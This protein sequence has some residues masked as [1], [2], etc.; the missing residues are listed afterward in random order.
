MGHDLATSPEWS[1]RTR[2]LVLFFV[3]AIFSLSAWLLRELLPLLAV[4]MVLSFLLSPIV[5][6]LSKRLHLF[7]YLPNAMQRGCAV[8]VA[9]ILAVSFLIVVTLVILPPIFM[10][11][12]DFGRSLPSLLN[13]VTQEAERILSEPVTF[14]GDPILIEG[15]PFV[16]LDRIEDATG[17][18]RLSQILQLNSADFNNAVQSFVGSISIVTGPA[19]SFLGGAFNVLVNSIFLVMMTFYLMKDGHIFVDRIIRLLPDSYIEDGRRVT[20]DL[21]QVWQAYI[22]GQLLLCVVMGLAVYMAALILGLPN[23]AILGLLA[24]LLEF[25]PTLGPFIALVPAA[26]L[27]LVSQSMTLPFLEGLPFMI[28]VIV[29][30]TGLQNLESIFL[31]PRIMGQSLNLHPFV[32]ILAV[33]GGAALAGGL[34]VILAAP[35]LASLRV[36]ATYVHGKLTNRSPFMERSRP[37]LP[38]LPPMLQHIGERLAEFVK[39]VRPGPRA[40]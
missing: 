40:S 19:F 10:Q 2:S 20:G 28:V 16:P 23:A 11:I 9:F 27:A 8:I 21:G 14:Q 12:Q 18:R 29:V 38:T 7:F 25:I 36:L 1:P 22:R 5:N 4:S 26:L 3:V 37:D 34:G 17:T 30:W 13:T 33:L 15:E 39:S 24:G 35:T 32:V 31:V 6:L